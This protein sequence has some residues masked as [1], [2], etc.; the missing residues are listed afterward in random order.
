MRR[1]LRPF[2]AFLGEICVFC[3]LVSASSNFHRGDGRALLEN[4]RPR[5]LATALGERN[6]VGLDIG[7]RRAVVSDVSDC[8]VVLGPSVKIQS[9]L[10]R[11]LFSVAC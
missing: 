7:T 10:E 8:R 6:P 9:R 11:N 3:D 5:T 1:V 4:S 2:G